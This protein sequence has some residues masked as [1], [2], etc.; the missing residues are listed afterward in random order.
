MFTS[1]S[2]GSRRGVRLAWLSAL[3]VLLVV[4]GISLPLA[5]GSLGGGSD[6]DPS[7]VPA[8]PIG[9]AESEPTAP[10]V[11]GP[12]IRFGE[13]NPPG[14]SRTAAPTQE[15]TPTKPRTVQAAGEPDRLIVPKLGI[16]HPVIDIYASDG[17]LVPP[18]D[19]QVLG[20]WASGAKPG[21]RYGGALITGH[22]VS[23]GGGAFD[24]LETLDRGD[25]VKVRTS[26]GVVEYAVTGVTIYRKATL[27]EDAE[28]IF[29]QTVPG[30]LV[31][32]TCEDWNGTTYLS[33]AVVF[34]EPL[35]A[36]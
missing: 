34:A 13:A 1:S 4:A 25:R 33:N 17:V 2:E 6:N 36:A 27:A 28:Q 30:R 21:A 14:P 20:W 18:G 12:T 7:P 9:A 35:P 15:A 8:A 24:H 16:D 3:G 11:V 29:S 26:S 10:F 23:S 32:V 22:T 5:T 31:L 19:P